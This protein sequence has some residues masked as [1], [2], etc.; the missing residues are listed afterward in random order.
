MTLFWMQL[1]G[2]LK[3]VI[4][5]RAFRWFILWEEEQVQDWVPLFSI[6]SEMSLRE[7]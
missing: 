2:K 6:E 4:I 1:G 5:W 7:D 3:D